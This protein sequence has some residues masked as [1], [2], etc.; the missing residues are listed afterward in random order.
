LVDPPEGRGGGPRRMEPGQRRG[1]GT[2]RSAL[3]AAGLLRGDQR[4]DDAP[5][6][7]DAAA[8]LAES[9]RGADDDTEPASADVPAAGRYVNDR[10]LMAEKL[11][12]RLRSGYAGKRDDDGSHRSKPPRRDHPLRRGE[13]V[14]DPPSPTTYLPMVVGQRVRPACAGWYRV[15]GL[16]R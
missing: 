9:W 12:E 5:R 8:E 13:R 6:D 16:T 4:G 3:A 14:H 2:A 1:Q 10:E 15:S 7:S 11:G